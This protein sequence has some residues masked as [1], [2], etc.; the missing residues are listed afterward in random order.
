MSVYMSAYVYIKQKFHKTIFA[1]TIAMY[2][3]FLLLFLFFFNACDNPLVVSATTN[4]SQPAVW[5]TV[6]QFRDNE[7]AG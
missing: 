2:C 5:K 1:L 4:K 7:Y 6:R 3:Y